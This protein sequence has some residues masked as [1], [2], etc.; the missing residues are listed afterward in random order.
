VD[1]DGGLKLTP[2][3]QK[4]HFGGWPEDIPMVGHWTRAGRA[5]IGIYRGGTWLIDLTGNPDTPYTRQWGLSGDKPLVGDFDGDGKSDYA[6]WRPVNGAWYIVPSS[7]PDSP[8]TRQWGVPDDI[9]VAADFDGDGKTDFAVWRPV[10]GTW[11]ISLSSTGASV[12]RQWGLPGDIPMAADYDGD[13]KADYAVWRPGE[14]IWHISASSHPDVPR[15]KRY[16]AQ[17]PRVMQLGMPG[18]IPVAG[19]YDGDGKADLAVWRPSDGAWY[20]LPSAS[21]GTLLQGSWNI[22]AE[23]PKYRP[24][25]F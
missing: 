16:F 21:P 20:I 15:L 2:A 5:E 10:N 19:D 24:A 4:Y 22:P 23:L 12:V 1:W 13:G 7:H 25:G 8:I 18:D 11:Y 14:G 17:A 9:P 6:V 3:H